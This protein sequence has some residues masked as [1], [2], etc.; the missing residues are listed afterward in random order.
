[1]IIFAHVYDEGIGI[2]MYKFYTL[3]QEVIT[4][5]TL[6]KNIRTHIYKSKAA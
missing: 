3:W 6:K 2:I 1:M 4:K 5:H